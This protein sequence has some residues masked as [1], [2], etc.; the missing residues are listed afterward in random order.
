MDKARE[1]ADTTKTVVE[2]KVD[3]TKKVV[4]SAEKASQAVT[5]FRSNLDAL[6]SLTGSTVSTGS[7]NSGSLSPETGS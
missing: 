4:E 6:T 2:T 3:Q 5:E 7:T 1:V